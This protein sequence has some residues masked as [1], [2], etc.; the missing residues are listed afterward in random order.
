[1]AIEKWKG[2]SIVGL[3]ILVNACLGTVYSWSVFREP[4]ESTIGISAGQ[5]GLPYAVFLAAFAFSMPLAGYVLSHV[6]SRLTLLIGGLLVGA[7]WISAGISSSLVALTLT[8]GIVGGV[9]VGFGYGV[10]LAVAGSHHPERRGLAMG[11]TLAGFGV[12]PFV[13]APLAELLIVRN[14]VQTAMIV[15]GIAYIVVIGGL[16]PLFRI[17]EHAVS[18]NRIPSTGDETARHSV[19]SAMLRTREFYT[20]WVCFA[21]ATLSGLTAIGMTASYGHRTIGL[22]VPVAAATVSALGIANGIGRPVFG[23]VHDRFGVRFTATL[24]FFVIAAGGAF[25]FFSTPDFPVAFFVGFAVLWFMLGGWLAIA[26]AATTHLYG[27]RN[28][29]KNYGIVYTAY[30]VGAL[31]GSSLSGLIVDRFGGYRPLFALIT[32]LSLLGAL[33]SWFGFRRTGR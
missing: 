13:T 31:T 3:G 19:P 21:I 10:P 22:S 33:I 15:L 16:S 17:K 6:G 12:S 11:L 4:L 29:A 32:A 25:S 20:L 2:W 8:Y 30:G 7:G 5:S 14:G 23:L 28:Y 27:S 26:P 9:G 18:S 24:S 1:M